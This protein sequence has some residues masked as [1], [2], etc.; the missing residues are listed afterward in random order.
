MTRNWRAPACYIGVALIGIIYIWVMPTVGTTDL[1]AGAALGASLMWALND[2]ELR[3]RARRRAG[4]PPVL[5]VL[6]S[7]ARAVV[8]AARGLDGSEFPVEAR[9]RSGETRPRGEEIRTHGGEAWLGAE[10]ARPRQERRPR[11]E[12]VQPRG[13]EARPRH[14]EV[15]SDRD[16]DRPA[17]ISAGR[18]RAEPTREPPPHEQPRRETP[19]EAWRREVRNRDVERIEAQLRVLADEPQE[20]PFGAPDRQRQGAIPREL[21]DRWQRPPRSRV[22]PR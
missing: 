14:G 5:R 17:R 3:Q 2:W 6:A 16:E 9:P 7:R 18:D 12:D 15:R 20:Q 11:G 22:T 21:P 19:I 8:R 1:F 10:D 13:T 4:K